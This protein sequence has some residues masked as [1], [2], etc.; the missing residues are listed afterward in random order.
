MY[1]LLIVP[2]DYGLFPDRD[3]SER[4]AG[5]PG[6]YNCSETTIGD[7]FSASFDYQGDSTIVRLSEDHQRISVAGSGPASTRLAVLVAQALASLSL[8]LFD[9]D[10]SF[11]IPLDTGTS[12]QALRDQLEAIPQ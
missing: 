1:F 10:Y 6:L 7:R 2:A 9:L 3:T 5:I 12:E 11:D 4:L 8:R